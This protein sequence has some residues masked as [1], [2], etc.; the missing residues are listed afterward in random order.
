MTYFIMA[1]GVLLLVLLLLPTLAAGQ[2]T[3]EDT[4]RTELEEEQTQ[5]LGNLKELEAAGAD[6]G[7]M[8]REKVRL[9]QVLQELDHLP[10]PATTRAHRPAL[11]TALALLLGV[12]L[13]TLGGVYT[14][15][16]QWRYSG[17]RQGEAAQLQNA[18]RIP[19]LQAKADKSGTTADFMTLGDTA[20]DAQNYQ[21]AAKSYTQVLLKERT[22][23][24]ALRRTGFYLLGTG[25]MARDGLSFIQR[26]VAADP[27]A[28]EGQLLYG[29]A[30]GLFGQ[31][32]EGLKVLKN[33]QALAPD[34]HEADDLIVEFQQKTG[35][36]ISGKLVYAQNCAACH[37]AAGEG[38]KGPKLVGAPAL[39]DEKALRNKILAGGMAMPA[40]PQLEGKQL[41]ALI[42]ELQGW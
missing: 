3:P 36:A 9:A 16:P 2:T 41:D 12:A 38:G 31:Y 24:K 37:G 20:W 15:F 30:L 40:F 29:Y 21:L 7:V 5:L 28:P 34:S 8:T 1:L 35:T 25:E 42:K 26:G 11:P 17:L 23:A 19:A 32:Q 13:I 14:V 33:Y 39:K 18:S 4:R 10:A 6:A 22:N 27:K